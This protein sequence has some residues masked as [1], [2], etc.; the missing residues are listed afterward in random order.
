MSAKNLNSGMGA[1][2]RR[3]A[4][5]EPKRKRAREDGQP[6]TKR[7]AA[8]PP[9]SGRNADDEALAVPAKAYEPT[10]QEREAVANYRAGVRAKP[11]VPSIKV[12]QAKD[13]SNQLDLD[14]PDKAIAACLLS[15]A[16]GTKDHDFLQLH[17]MHY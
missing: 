11:A 14:H 13:G 9:R 4:G 5:N 1:R 2:A 8:E 6:P 10:P 3:G 16:L 15:E 12:V 17:P 7:H